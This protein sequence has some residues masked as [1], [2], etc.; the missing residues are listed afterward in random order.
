MED[1]DE[2]ELEAHRCMTDIFFNLRKHGIKRKPDWS[3]LRLD[4][5]VHDDFDYSLSNNPKLEAVVASATPLEHISLAP[6]ISYQ[7]D[8]VS[9]YNSL[10]LSD[11]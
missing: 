3:L 5:E 11:Q 2:E 1:L 8:F 4:G 10:A 6:M 9:I 7:M